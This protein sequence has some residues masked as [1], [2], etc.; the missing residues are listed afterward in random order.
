MNIIDAIKDENLFRPFLGKLQSWRNWLTALRVLYGLPLYR[1][2]RRTVQ[3]CTG[4]DWSRLPRAGFET[5]L[6]LTG[7]RSG[8][9]RCAAII[10]AY[11][12][13][14]AGH[15]RRL[16]K[17]ERGVVPVISPTKYQSRIVRD[18]IRSIF[19]TPLLRNEVKAETRDGFELHSGTRIE[20]LAGDWRTVRGYTLLAA[21]VEE[22]CFFGYDAESKVKND[23]ELIRALKPS[24]ATVGGKLICISSPY[25]RKGWCYQQWKRHYGRDDAK[26]LVWNCPSRTMNP[27]LPQAVVDEAIAEDMQAARSEYL[28]EFR[29]D[30]AE[31]LP[32]T[33]IERLVMAGR[34]ELLPQRS[35]S[36]VAF[37]DLSGGRHDDAALAVAHREER[38]VVVDCVKRYRPPFNPHEVVAQMAHELR[39]YGVRRVTGD[40][41]AAEFVA[42]AFESCGIRYTKAP[43]AKSV[44]YAELLPRLCSNEIELPDS[45]P[46]VS[47]LAGLERRTRSGGRDIIDHPPGG[48]DDLA[49]A[50][51][52][53]ADVACTRRPLV[54]AF[55]RL[56]DSDTDNIAMTRALWSRLIG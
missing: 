19:E 36:Y 35:I 16:A 42:G 21:I 11:E 40:N 52:G 34:V 45:E 22:A 17:G 13:A 1:P 38:K 50:V 51:A 37:A 47:Q 6:F 49:N 29:D 18:Y 7:R 4:R 48:H 31:F 33:V 32:R 56:D 25:A 20:I 54:G 41:Y 3:Q 53:V 24:L 10:G 43:K 5:G 39:R 2:G 15:E 28:G 30:V 23:S 55:P 12:A 9:S 14:L 8:K 26:V 27:T 44:L 46:L